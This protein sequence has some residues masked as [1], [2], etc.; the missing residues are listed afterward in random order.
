V[1]NQLDFEI[2]CFSADAF[3]LGKGEK[4]DVDVPADL[5]QFG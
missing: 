1:L 5:D 4:F 3:D 2:A